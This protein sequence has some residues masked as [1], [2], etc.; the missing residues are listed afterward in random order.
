MVTASHFR[1]TSSLLAPSPH[2]VYVPAIHMSFRCHLLMFDDSINF[3]A[4]NINTSIESV[5][6]H[7]IHSFN[8]N[9]Y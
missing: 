3:F 2:Q 9:F 5:P 4:V 6:G 8:E 1:K 7:K